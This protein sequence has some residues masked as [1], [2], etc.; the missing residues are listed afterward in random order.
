LFLGRWF[1]VVEHSV[2]GV[3]AR[4]NPSSVAAEQVSGT[5]D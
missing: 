2:L 5:G 4:N 3:A 1:A